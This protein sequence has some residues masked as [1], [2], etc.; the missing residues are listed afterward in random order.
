MS[1]DRRIGSPLG[2]VI[3]SQNRATRSEIH[4]PVVAGCQLPASEE[5]G[6]QSCS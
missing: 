2:G 5:D 1:G 4:V 3:T 6:R